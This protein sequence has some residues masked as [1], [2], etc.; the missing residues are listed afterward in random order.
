MKGFAASLRATFRNNRAQQVP[1]IHDQLQLSR[2]SQNV[3]GNEPAV[4]RCEMG[5]SISTVFSKG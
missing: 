4:A 1:G 5:R 3:L 2:S